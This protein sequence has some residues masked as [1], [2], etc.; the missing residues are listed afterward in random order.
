MQALFATETFAMGL[1]MPAK[2][3]VFTSVRKFDGKEH[4]WVS[5]GEYIQ[6]SGRAGRR[7]LDDKGI[8]IQMVDE[9]M[10]PH[11]AMQLL[12]GEADKLTS[13]FHVTYNMLLNLLRVE[14]LNPEYMLE[15]SF[16][17]FQHRAAV[18]ELEDK[19]AKL[20]AQRDAMVI[21]DESLVA[22][23]YQIRTQLEKLS[24]EMKA[25]LRQP[26]HV[27]QFLNPGR[28]A[29]IVDGPDD[30]GWGVVVNFQKKAANTKTDTASDDA[31]YIVEM[32][33]VCA[34]G[35]GPS[36]KPRPCGLGEKGEAQVIPVLL[37]LVDQLSSVRVYLPKDL[38]PADARRQVEKTIGEVQARF[39]GG[40][41]VLDPI[42]D[43]KI[44][45]PAFIKLLKV[46]SRTF[47]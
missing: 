35:K 12:K 7:G 36:A 9:K 8:V 38:R 33:L 31:R 4:R 34:S 14:E 6:M 44:D 28:L 41:P 15:R 29:H 11:V 39:P 46:C 43:M 2:T 5:G 23:Y 42:E 3:V 47:T 20:E 21:D 10:E 30:W 24:V 18:P 26:E 19:R 17:Q 13:A 16:F 22:E 25:T 37:D 1:N 40:L 45:D 27:L 32:L